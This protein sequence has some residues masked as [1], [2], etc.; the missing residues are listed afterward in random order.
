MVQN[1]C[2][3]FPEKIYFW[4]SEIFFVKTDERC[5]YADPPLAPWQGEG[6]LLAYEG[7]NGGYNLGN[8]DMRHFRLVEVSRGE[9]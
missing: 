3:D 5:P 2:C 1:K 8:E 4:K 7:N 9:N 6:A